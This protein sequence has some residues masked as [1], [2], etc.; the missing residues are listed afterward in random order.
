MDRLVGTLDYLSPEQI[1]GREVDPRTDLYAVGLVL[2]ESLARRLPDT[3]DSS[4]GVLLSRVRKSAAGVRRHRKDVPRWLERVIR[5][6]LEREPGDRYPSAAAVREALES[7]RSWIWPLPRARRRRLQVAAGLL[8]A[9][10]VVAILALAFLPSRGNERFLQLVAAGADEIRAVDGHGTTLWSLSGVD[11]QIG[12]GSLYT[13]ARLAPHEP[14]RLVTVLWPPGDLRPEKVGTLSIMDP[15]TGRSLRTV[16]LPLGL[17]FSEYSDFFRPDQFSAVDLDHDGVDEVLITYIQVPY[18]P[19]FTVLYE[20][21]MNRAR[22]VFAARG[23]HRFAGARDLTGDGRPEILFFGINNDLDWYN[24][25]AAV[26]VVPWIGEPSLAHGSFTT[27]SPTML[28]FPESRRN[29][30]WY[31]LLPRGRPVWGTRG[32]VADPIAHTLKFQYQDGSAIVLDDEGFPLGNS[33]R[34]APARRRTSRE[35]AYAHLRESRRLLAAG[36]P[37]QA[38][39]EAEAGAAAA[40]EASLPLLEQALRELR[41]RALVAA[42][43]YHE[44]RQAFDELARSSDDASDISYQAAEA[45]HLAGRLD[46]ALRWYQRGLGKGAGEDG[47]RMKEDFLRGAV[48]ALV[49]LHRWDDALRWIQRYQDAYAE[50]D[51]NVRPYREFVRW[52][53]GGA[54]PEPEPHLPYIVDDFRRYWNLEFRRLAGR[55]P[56]EVLLHAVA[57]DLER[58]SFTRPLLLSLEAELLADEGNDRQALATARRAVDLT[59]QEEMTDVGVRAHAGLIEERL[60]RLEAAAGRKERRASSSG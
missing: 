36:A 29:L 10:C 22:I 60:D 2:Y 44:A 39:G 38:L 31:A 41:G 47:G 26:R 5:R 42:G 12:K 20:P 17:H 57:A 46:E 6:L 35:R 1:L 3:A 13:L 8:V 50:A 51:Q 59:H 28:E 18:A 56:P 24:A 48:F 54:K 30:L 4:V 21:T 23:Q 45:F 7:R 58:T 15:E 40:R 14:K 43:R 33:L 25:A 16:K 9:A 55:E 52:I 32:L 49:E 19:S 11:P 53:R 37:G 34:E 27:R